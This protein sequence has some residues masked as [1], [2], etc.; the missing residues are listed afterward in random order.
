MNKRDFLRAGAAMLPAVFF[1][2]TSFG[3]E[4]PPRKPVTLVVGFAAGGGNDVAARMIAKRLAER[5]GQPVTVDNRAGAGGNIAHAYV[6]HAPADGSVILLGSIGPLTIAP[7]L[8]KLTYDPMTDLTPLTM[9]LVFPNV[10]VVPPTLGVSTLAEF[11]SLAKAKPGG[12][13]FASTG[14]GSSSHLT[15]E[16]FNQRAGVEITHIPYKGGSAAMVDLL[17]GRISA[18]YSNPS[19][20]APHI[21]SGKVIALASTGLT[22]PGSL[23]R[24]PTIA[25]SGYPGFDATNWNAFVAPRNTP[26]SIA[27]GWNRELVAVMN[28]PDV[29]D[30]LEK[31]GL[32]PQPGTPEE[33]TQYM[34]S[35]SEVWGKLIRER[36]ITAD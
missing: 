19:T 4:F 31:H 2:R 25:E 17:G 29:R 28:T 15:G 3:Q 9:G 30:Q 5:V 13:D 27:A 32:T 34:I 20:A 8:M 24:L 12:L 26:P 16:L 6:A 22:R 18:Y 1:S 33:L 14:A 23:A 10:L 21:E 35:Q 7:H 36:K 11:V